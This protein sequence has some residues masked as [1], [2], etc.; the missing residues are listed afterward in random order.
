[1]AVI[2]Q[3]MIDDIELTI[4]KDVA[5]AFV[6][7]RY[8]LNWSKFDQLTNLLYTEKWEIVGV[9][10]ASTTVLYTGPILVAG[11]SSNGAAV[12]SREKTATIPWADLD[13]DPTGMDE[14]AAVVTLT[15]QLPVA[16]Q[17]QSQQVTVSAP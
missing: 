10:P 7:L 6:T 9:D 12:T 4:D 5:N 14:I 1:M 8:N 2:F 17:A 16:R 13:E 11:V 15:P 3:P